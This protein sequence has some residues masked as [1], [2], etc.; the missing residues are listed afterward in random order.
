MKES[1]KSEAGFWSTDSRRLKK[2]IQ[3][4]LREAPLQHDKSPREQTAQFLADHPYSAE[5]KLQRALQEAVLHY[6]SHE[7]SCVQPMRYVQRGHK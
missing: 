5:E 6:T 4:A 2:L 1:E 3:E 7:Q